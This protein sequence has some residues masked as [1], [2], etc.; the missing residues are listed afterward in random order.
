MLR[1]LGAPL[2]VFIISLLQ[3][4][5]RWDKFAYS[6]SFYVNIQIDCY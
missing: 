2:G 1:I 3:A 4:L 6:W 5:W